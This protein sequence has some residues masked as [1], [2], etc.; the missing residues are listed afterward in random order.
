MLGRMSIADELQ[1]RAHKASAEG[2]QRRHRQAQAAAAR[3]AATVTE[4]GGTSGA[5]PAFLAQLAAAQKRAHTIANAPL[6]RSDLDHVLERLRAEGKLPALEKP[7]NVG[8]EPTPEEILGELAHEASPASDPGAI[9]SLPTVEDVLGGEGT[10]ANEPAEEPWDDVPEPAPEPVSEAIPEAKAA[11]TRAMLPR[12][13]L[14]PGA[15][16]RQ[17]TGKRG[18]R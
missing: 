1:R 15:G 13:D 14:A 5:H 12:G 8:Y 6:E 3:L 17:A 9:E 16:A 10:D 11:P 7:D 4:H 18:R 2:I